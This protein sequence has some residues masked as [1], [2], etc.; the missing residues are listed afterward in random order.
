MEGREAGTFALELVHMD[1]A[2]RGPDI[3]FTFP[4]SSARSPFGM[5]GTDYTERAQPG[6]SPAPPATTAA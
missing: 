6:R 2:E 4:W 5:Q 3:V 1:H